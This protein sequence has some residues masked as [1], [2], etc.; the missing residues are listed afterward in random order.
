MISIKDL[1]SSAK[2]VNWNLAWQYEEQIDL[3]PHILYYKT[4][5]YF[6][7]LFVLSWPWLYLPWY[8]FAGPVPGTILGINTVAT[9]YFSQ[10]IA[11]IV[12]GKGLYMEFLHFSCDE[13]L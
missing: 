1:L 7:T 9:I 12:L 10:N 11:N 4:V 6:L 5:Q 8:I 3:F 13:Q 2:L